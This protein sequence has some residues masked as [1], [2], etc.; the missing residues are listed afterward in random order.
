M[1]DTRRCP[2]CAE[3]IRVEATRCRYCR[4]SVGGV[5][6]AGW[7]RN[8]GAVDP[9]GW[10][11]N[12]RERKL[13]GVTAAVAHGLGFPLAMVRVTFIVL[14]FA[15]LHLIGPA[16]YLALWLIIPFDPGADSLLDR[17]TAHVRALVASWRQSSPPPRARPNGPVRDHYAVPDVPAGTGG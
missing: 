10:H 11:R 13:A 7:Y 2:Y 12:H 15:F 1:A 14:T 17:G 16:L 4:S 3:D 5:D 8:A 9:A 6:G